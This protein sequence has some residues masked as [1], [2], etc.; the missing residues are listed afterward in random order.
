MLLVML[1]SMSSVTGYASAERAIEVSFIVP[2]AKGDI[3]WDRVVAFMK[4][5]ANDLNINLK[6]AYNDSGNRFGEKQLAAQ[7]IADEPK[8]D[9]LI[10]QVKRNS[11][12]DILK[13]SKKTG[14]LNF[15]INTEVADKD[16]ALIGKPRGAFPNWLGQI[17]PD[18]FQ[19]GYDLTNLLVSRAKALGLFANDKPIEMIA[20][21]GSR[22]SSAAI[23]RGEGLAHALS[24]H[25]NVKLQQLI[26]TD[27]NEAANMELGTRLLVRHPNTAL[28]WSGSDAIAI[29]ASK[30]AVEFGKRPGKDFLTA[31]VDWSKDGLEALSSEAIE[32]TFGSHFMEGGWALVLIHDYHHGLDFKSSVGTTI[33]TQFY[34]I[35]RDNLQQYR[36]IV[37]PAS[38]DRIDFKR[39]S[40][41]Y[42]PERKGYSFNVESILK[43]LR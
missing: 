7:L 18:D 38:F 34:A 9:Y 30:A 8:P 11:F 20:I 23:E 2:T 17:I 24:K 42:N 35:T 3:F 33:K 15:T 4:A 21:N 14:V 32:A 37:N 12:V 5:S 43:Q 31:G 22:V 29:S 19:A 13:M 1:S 41:L 26:Y 10:T 16:M 25:P 6:L 36:E 27:W 39:Y 40:R 28:I